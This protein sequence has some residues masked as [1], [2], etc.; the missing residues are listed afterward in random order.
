[1]RG[2]ERRVLNCKDCEWRA[3]IAHT[4]TNYMAHDDDGRACHAVPRLTA[5]KLIYF[6]LCVEVGV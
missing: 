3:T 2:P 5:L 6:F 1:M 4:C